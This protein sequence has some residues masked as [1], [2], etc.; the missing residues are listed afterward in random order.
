MGEPLLAPELVLGLDEAVEAAGVAVVSMETADVDPDE[1]E[2]VTV[3][4]DRD[5]L[6]EDDVSLTGLMPQLRSRLVEM[7]WK[8]KVL[9]YL[10]SGRSL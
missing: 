4:S 2:I 8:A 9:P 7:Y 6:A 10:H 5:A 3:E 1:E